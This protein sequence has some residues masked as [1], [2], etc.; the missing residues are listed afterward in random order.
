M[1][2]GSKEFYSKTVVPGLLKQLNVKSPMSV[3]RLK[4][5][6]L[7][8]GI[9]EAKNNKNLITEGVKALEKVTGQKPV[10]TLSTKDI[11][12]FKIRK[13]LAIGA[14]V[15]LRRERM[16]S[17]LTRLINVYLP[18][19]KDFRGLSRKSFDAQGNYSI[20]INDSR[21]FPELGLQSSVRGMSITFVLETRSGEDSQKMLELLGLPFRKK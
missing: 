2:K 9:G 15:T 5:I 20:G 14:M 21:V 1:D 3:P 12:A 13:N 10:S 6:T 11:A 17:F 4:K 16:F 7:N 19:V 18:R 8:L